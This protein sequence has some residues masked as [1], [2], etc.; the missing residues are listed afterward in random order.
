[1]RKKMLQDS[2]LLC[3][4]CKEQ[5]EPLLSTSGGPQSTLLSPCYGLNFVSPKICWDPDSQGD[6]IRRWGFWGV[7]RSWGWNSLVVCC[8]LVARSCP[9]FF[10]PH[11]LQ[12]ARLPSFTLSQSLLKFMSVEW[13]MPSNHLILCHPLLH[14]PSIFPSTKV[15][16]NES[17]LCIKWPEVLKFQLWHQS[18]Q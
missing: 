17:V 1:M 18:F 4:T 14:L 2:K 13:V 5:G 12:H 10:W 6:G 9:V 11:G 15:F 3:Y 16:S 8:C 7:M